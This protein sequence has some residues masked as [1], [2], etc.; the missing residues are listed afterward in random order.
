MCC[1]SDFLLVS[2]MLLPVFT[3]VVSA[4]EV[5]LINELHF[6]VQLSQE[7]A[8]LQEEKTLLETEVGRL[9]EQRDQS[10]DD[11][12]AATGWRIDQPGLTT[13]SQFPYPL[14]PS[15]TKSPLPSKEISQD[16][17]SP[18]FSAAPFST[19]LHP[20]YQTYGMFGSRQSPYMPHSPFTHPEH[21]IHVER[22]AARYPAPIHPTPVYPA[23]VPKS[24]Q[25]GVPDLP[26]V[27]TDLQ[28]QTPG[29]TTQPSVSEEER[30]DKTT[31][32]KVVSYLLYQ[33]LVKPLYVLLL[34]LSFTFRSRCILNVV[35]LVQ[36]R[37]IF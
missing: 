26:I 4:K 13:N 31:S 2:G 37:V 23:A 22:P 32:A 12:G 16:P 3:P 36:L 5:K 20:A 15:M 35:R 18:F 19:F 28:L 11:Q 17:N 8:E 14:L 27:G 34:Y 25:A 21:Q 1:F 6:L 24:A 33:D 9:E 10:G 29:L 7:K 30:P